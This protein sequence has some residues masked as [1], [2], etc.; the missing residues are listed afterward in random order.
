[1]ISVYLALDLYGAGNDTLSGLAAVQTRHRIGSISLFFNLL[2]FLP[3]V[4]FLLKMSLTRHRLFAT[5]LVR[6]A[7]R[8]WCSAGC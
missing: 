4:V 8:R 5:L 3:S 1:L 2:E 7:P 6:N